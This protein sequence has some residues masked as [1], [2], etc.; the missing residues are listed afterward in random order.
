[1]GINNNPSQPPYLIPGLPSGIGANKN[2][3]TDAAGN[4]Q[5]NF[6]REVLGANRTYYVSTTGSDSNTGLSAG[7]PFLTIQ[8]AINT[9]YNLDL[10]SFIATIQLADG[11]YTAGMIFNKPIV[12]GTVQVVGNTTTPNNVVISTSTANA[13][14]VENYPYTLKFYGMQLT[15]SG[16]AANNCLYA[17]STPSTILLSKVNFGAST[18]THIYGFGNVTINNDTNVSYEI[19]GGALRHVDMRNGA[20]FSFILGTITLVGT[21]A[22]TQFTNA[23]NKSGVYWYL[24]VFSGTATGQRY[25]VASQSAINTYGSGVTFLPGS[26][27]GTADAATYGLYT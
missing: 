2:V 14:Y 11:T 22:F 15:T 4:L 6:V 27:A 3:G 19:S 7:S 8:K 23:I 1:M 17:T 21:P 18:G 12:G 20:Q 10:N 5:S 9:I 24:P 26:T 25:Y 13:I 16:G